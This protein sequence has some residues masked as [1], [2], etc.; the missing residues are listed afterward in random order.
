MAEVNNNP[1]LKGQLAAKPER[2]GAFWRYQI[3]PVH[4]RFDAVEWFVWDADLTDDQ[5]FATVIRQEASRDA[6]LD[7]LDL[8]DSRA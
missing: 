5:G 1:A 6:A 7:G 3:A 8:T 2:L 4:T